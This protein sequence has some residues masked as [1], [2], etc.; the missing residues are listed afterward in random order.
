MQRFSIEKREAI[1]AKALCR[2]NQT[3]RE[4]AE[5]NGVG[6]STLQKW[7]KLSREGKPIH[8]NKPLTHQL[9]R[10][11]RFRL[12]CEAESLDE[13]AL[14]IFC[15]KNGI[16]SHQLQQ[17]KGEFMSNANQDK[18]QSRDAELKK[19]KAEIKLLKKELNRKDRALAETSALLILK[20]KANLIWGKDEDD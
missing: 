2:K 13:K 1:V 15:R 4:V 20:K 8:P 14:G 16:F 19:L 6:F 18:N 3:L 9:T 12:L 5:A 11:E 7:L 10:A 17:W